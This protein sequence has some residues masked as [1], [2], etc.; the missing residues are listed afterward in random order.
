MAATQEAR[1]SRRGKASRKRRTR[2]RAATPV[3]AAKKKS[4]RRRKVRVAVAAPRTSPSVMA[5]KKRT[6]KKRRKAATKRHAPAKRRATSRRKVAREAWYGEP[7]R[8]ATAARKGWKGRRTGKKR[9]S[10]KTRESVAAPRRRRSGL[11]MEARRSSRVRAASRR[12]G[13]MNG[14]EFAL[15]LVSSGLGYVLADGLDRFLATYDPQTTELPKDKF[16]SDGA[17]TLANTLNVASTP[18][19]L[20]IAAGIGVAAA[21]A[22]GAMYAKNPLVRSSLEGAALGAGIS[23]FK[24][25]WNNVVMSQLLKP[26]DTSG[27]G[28]RASVIARLYPAEVAAAVNRANSLTTSTGTAFG[29]LSQAPA[30][31]GPFALSGDSAY[32]DAAQALQREAAGVQEQFPS[33]QNV[34]GTAEAT[35]DPGVAWQPVSSP[36]AVLAAPPASG[37]AWQPGPASDVGP[38]PQ[39]QEAQCACLGDDNQFLGFIGDADES[40]LLTLS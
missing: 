13:G 11:V 26:K 31:V 36:V 19:M 38:G 3:V 9:R 25:V 2:A 29:A 34:W 22:V 12:S 10:R 16:T 21:P 30:D 40:S 14:V 23:I 1:R 28:M 24:T 27:L 6:T 20:R 32:P 4:R 17:G 39:P 33:L 15:A 35:P 7:A 18:N 37:V 8:H 5:R